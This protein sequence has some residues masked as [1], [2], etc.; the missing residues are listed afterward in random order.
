MTEKDLQYRMKGKLDVCKDCV[1]VNRNH[2]SLHKVA[3]DIDLNMGKMIY[4]DII[5]KKKP[6][7]GGY[8]NWILFQDFYT[9]Q[10][11]YFFMKAK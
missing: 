3:E 7:Y 8:K 1:M 10:K 6:S 2:K 11:Y 9:K 5:S 4:L